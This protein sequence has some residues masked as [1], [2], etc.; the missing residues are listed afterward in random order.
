MVINLIQFFTTQIGVYNFTLI[1]FYFKVSISKGTEFSKLHC[2]D[3]VT[4]DFAENFHF[5]N[6]K[7]YGFKSPCLKLNLLMSRERKKS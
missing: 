4:M 7:K 5:N 3:K 6:T 1:V 2:Y